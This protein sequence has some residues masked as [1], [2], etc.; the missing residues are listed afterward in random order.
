M[1][2]IAGYFLKSGATAPA[3][4]LDRFAGLMTHRG[5]DGT[6]SKSIGQAGFVHTRLAIVDL[7]GGQQPFTSDQK[8]AMANGE[9]YNHQA[10]RGQLPPPERPVSRSDCAVLL[11][12]FSRHGSQFVDQL[13]GMYALAAYD[14][15][16]DRGLLARDA[17]GIKPLY[18]VELESGIYFASEPG[19]LVKA[20]LVAADIDPQRAAL[21]LD[22]QYYS[23]A[24]VICSPIKRLLP[25]EALEIA[26]GQITDRTY[27]RPLA[28][29]PT[30][31]SDP[32]ELDSR[33]QDT[34]A[35]HQMADV[36]FGMFLSGG[37]DS[38][39]LLALM[40]RLNRDAGS[41]SVLAYTARFPDAPVPDETGLA[42]H[43]A[44]Q[45]GAQFIDCPYTKADFFADAGLAVA[46]C[47]D[48]AAD[49][50][51]LPSLHLARRAARDVKIILSG[52]G[53]DEFFAGY[54]RYRRRLSLW[55][56]T[57]RPRPGPALK[58]GLL[59]AGLESE[60]RGQLSRLAAQPDY[61]AGFGMRLLDRD[62]A[63][64][65]IQRA[66]IDSWLP[67]NLLI[68]LDRCLMQASVEGRTPFIDR[69]LS[70]WGYQLPARAKLRGRH[71]KYLL[72]NWLAEHLPAARPF[73]RKRGF[74]V[75]AG[76]WAASEAARLAPLLERLPV[77][78]S[79]VKPGSIAA[80]LEA[81]RKEGDYPAVDR[82]G[83]LA[84]RLLFFGL[85]EQIHLHRV[86]PNQPVWDILA[87][88]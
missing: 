26:N 36:P 52:E 48:P 46:A 19:V 11:P 69:Q 20:G 81:G 59:R 8:M 41:G 66:D 70:V 55:P 10:L 22:Q 32:A 18:Y 63:L 16:Q 37:I 1:C 3:G 35:A 12:L 33:L 73:Q 84:W 51:I 85:W 60:L 2:G 58:A 24:E 71:G 23:G 31:N 38:S 56:S 53:G 47:D 14:G 25:G 62:R 29:V 21:L 88:R 76:Y 40:T 5:P 9:I 13:R 87:T 64:R 79:L 54:G 27:D 65:H 39:I 78:G 42:R 74:S 45:C 83:L 43:L 80:V 49:Y 28:A 72:Q 34:V 50:A 4:L 44:A 68:K 67:D 17:F 30:G 6:A 61:S 15:W 75:P 57:P 82:A 77:L 7:A 86:E